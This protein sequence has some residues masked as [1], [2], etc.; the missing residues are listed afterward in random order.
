M[1]EMHVVAGKD[2]FSVYF[3]AGEPSGALDSWSATSVDELVKK[4]LNTKIDVA[5]MFLANS[6]F[7][8]SPI[9]LIKTGRFDDFQAEKLRQKSELESRLATYLNG[10][11]HRVLKALLSIA[12]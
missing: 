4:F 7:G 9:E 3:D 11:S 2:S 12:P 10:A 5:A 1:S 8:V 6:S